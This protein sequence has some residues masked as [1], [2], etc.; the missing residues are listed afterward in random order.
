MEEAQIT[1]SLSSS[2]PTLWNVMEEYRAWTHCLPTVP[3]IRDV[4]FCMFV[5]QFLHFNIPDVNF[6]FPENTSFRNFFDKGQLLVNCAF[7]HLKNIS[8]SSSLLKDKTEFWVLFPNIFWLLLIYLYYLPF[9][10]HTLKTFPLSCHSD[11]SLQYVY[12]NIYYH[13]PI[14]KLR[15]T[16]S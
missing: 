16:N 1:N 11:A 3:S 2:H 9:S 6:L 13:L 10:S 15:V 7:V 12:V 14:T 5:C 8:V 4:M